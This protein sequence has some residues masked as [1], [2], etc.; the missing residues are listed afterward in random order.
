M[1]EIKVIWTIFHCGAASAPLR[2]AHLRLRQTVGIGTNVWT[3]W[4]NFEKK[5]R[6]DGWLQAQKLQFGTKY[7]FGKYFENILEII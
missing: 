7:L 6:E 2:Q 1:G 3:F 5:L 4:E